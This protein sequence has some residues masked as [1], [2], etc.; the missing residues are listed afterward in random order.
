MLSL[1][2]F[3][4]AAAADTPSLDRHIWDT[5]YRM[6][7][8]FAFSSRSLHLHNKI[9]IHVWNIKIGYNVFLNM[10]ILKKNFV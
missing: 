5:A 2:D 4:S 10:K 1:S 6:L 3:R 9:Y 8:S 7:Y